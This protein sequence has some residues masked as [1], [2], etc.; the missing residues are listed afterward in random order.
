M[1]DVETEVE[2]VVVVAAEAEVVREEVV[3]AVT[4]VVGLAVPVDVARAAVDVVGPANQPA[5]ISMTR[6]AAH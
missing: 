2:A 4:E 3:G 6:H 5:S 1:P